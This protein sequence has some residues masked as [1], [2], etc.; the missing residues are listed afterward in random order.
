MKIDISQLKKIIKEEL[1]TVMDEEVKPIEDL[2]KIALKNA[3]LPE[4]IELRAFHHATPS[5]RVFLVPKKDEY[6]AFSKMYRPE[7][8]RTGQLV[9][10]EDKPLIISIDASKVGMPIDVLVDALKGKRLRP[11]SKRAF[12]GPSYE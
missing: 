6:F 7:R 12:T 5:D 2:I 1:E 4:D 3:E 9:F 10:P 8:D 11:I